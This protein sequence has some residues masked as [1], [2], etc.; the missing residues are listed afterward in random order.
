MSPAPH[1]IDPLSW[2]DQSPPLLFILVPPYLPM[3]KLLQMSRDPLPC[4]PQMRNG[5]P[6]P[7]HLSLSSD[8]PIDPHGWLRI[9][10][11][12]PL[13]RAP[14]WVIIAW[15]IPPANACISCNDKDWYDRAWCEDNQAAGLLP[16]PPLLGGGNSFWGLRSC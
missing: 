4:P 6:P 15:Y 12:Q 2:V 7:A 9:K 5:G 1:P 10:W 16:L 14:N 13:P 11:I 8:T 3:I